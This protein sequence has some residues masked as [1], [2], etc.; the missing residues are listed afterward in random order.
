MHDGS[1]GMAFESTSKMRDRMEFETG[2]IEE[3]TKKYVLSHTSID[4]K[5]YDEKYRVEWYMLP[6]EAKEYHICDYIVGEDCT[7][8]E[9]I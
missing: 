6:H 3:L 1:T 7:I 8:D 5:Y 4:S 2:Q 9:V